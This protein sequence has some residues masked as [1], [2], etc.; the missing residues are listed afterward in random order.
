MAAGPTMDPAE[1]LS[2]QLE[3]ASPDLLRE[4][5]ATFVVQV[6]GVEVDGICAAGYGE[7]SPARPALAPRASE[8]ALL[9][10]ESPVAGLAGTRQ[11][12]PCSWQWPGSRAP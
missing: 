8:I 7:Q 4:I 3:Q 11:R 2:K 1:W 12:G 5:V 9:R 6:M 10:P